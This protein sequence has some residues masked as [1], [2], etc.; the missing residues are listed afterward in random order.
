V[1]KPKKVMITCAIT[2]A[3][4]SPSMSPYLPITAR[5]MID[6]SIGAVQ[7]GA[8]IL[9]LH[10]RIP[11]DGRP[12][13]DVSV[14]QSFVPGIRAGC[15]AVINMSA[16]MGATAEDRVSAVLAMRPEVA[17]VIVGS[18]NYGRFKKAQDQQVSDFEYDWER[19]FYGPSSYN[20]VTQNTFF[21][22]DRMIDILTENKIAMEF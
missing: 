17:T 4:L 19:E 16:S 15:D 10:A 5:Q 9:H 8:S 21:K 14:W 7:A 3:T 13:N 11:E 2:G 6:E 18:M 20:I 12:T 22:I 1:V